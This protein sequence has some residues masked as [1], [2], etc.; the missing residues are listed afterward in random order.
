MLNWTHY[1]HRQAL[2]VM[3]ALATMQAEHEKEL[4]A[5]NEEIKYWRHAAENAIKS[6][7]RALYSHSR[8][9]KQFFEFAVCALISSTAFIMLIFALMSFWEWANQ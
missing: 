3:N 2:E 8:Q 9:V 6:R 1:T 7:K 4:I 5:K